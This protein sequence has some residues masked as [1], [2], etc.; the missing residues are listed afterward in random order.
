MLKKTA[1]MIL[2]GI[3]VSAALA[4]AALPEDYTPSISP[5]QV[6]NQTYITSV[7]ILMFVT[8]HGNFGRDLSGVFGYDYGTFYPF[9]T[10]DAIQDGSLTSSVLYAAGLWLGGKVN[11]EIRVAV[12]EYSDEYTPGTFEDCGM[13]S[14]DFRVLTLYSDSLEG[15]G[16]YDYYL[17]PSNIGAPVDVNGKP[18]IIGDEMVWTVFS[19]CNPSQHTNNSGETNPL[20][21]E[22]QMTGWTIKNRSYLDRTIFLKYK[23]YN[24]GENA[25]ND[26]YMGLWFDS[27]LG[28]AYDDL[29]GCDTLKNIFYTYN[30]DNDDTQF[31][32]TT[33]AFGVKV[34]A[35]PVI[36]SANDTAFFDGIPIPGY[37]NIGLT[38]FSGYVN[39]T[40]PDNYIETY[41]YMQGLNRD[42]TPFSNGTKFM[43]PGNPVTGIGDLDS[44]P[45]D[46]RMMGNFGPIPEF[47]PGDS[48]FVMIAITVGQGA[49]N[50]SSITAMRD[51]FS[52]LVSNGLADDFPFD[53][54]AYLVA[55]TLYAYMANAVNPVVKTLYFGNFENTTAAEVVSNGN[56]TIN[57][58]ITPLS[59][60]VVPAPF[61]GF[62][63]Y[64]VKAE[65]DVRDLIE[66]YEPLWDITE[67]TFSVGFAAA[68]LNPPPPGIT[69]TVIMKGHI[70]GDVNLDGTLNVLDILYLIQHKF[71]DG[72][73]PRMFA[74][75]DVNV[76]GV[77]N[78]LDII[79][80]VNYMYKNGAPL[81][82]P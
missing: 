44:A 35:G 23:I 32:S 48:Q 21:V 43:F 74:T 27:D 53:P 15:N 62:T 19:D 20:G 47:A 82:H 3:F 66:V 31:G 9:T 79:A 61:G 75:A 10:I 30:G 70:S 51:N 63:G 80:M 56:I 64:V 33:P 26:F 12:A 13:E 77:I 22:V 67:Q 7:D 1:L 29:I 37:T 38:A 34:L 28:G 78:V 60:E 40:D 2:A 18:L 76:D 25:I 65:I 42:G 8:N 46:K 5:R 81:Q 11:N 36:P 6:D 68:P 41:N 73:A 14:P 45:M 57:G 72:P 58:D 16:S 39:G 59:A 17:W 54:T 55:D 52:S 4:Y 24:K 69:G 50:L 49:D 71:H